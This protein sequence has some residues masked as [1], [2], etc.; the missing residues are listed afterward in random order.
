MINIAVLLT[1]HNRKDKT[2]SCLSSLFAATERYNL[3]KEEGKN[4]GLDIFITDDGCTDGTADAIRQHF[5][6]GQEITIIKGDGSLYWNR[7]MIAAWEEALK[8]HSKYDYYLLLND[9]TYLMDN[10]FEELF[11]T[12]EYTVAHYSRAGIYSGI[13]CSKDDDNVTTYGGDIFTNRFLSKLK[14]LNPNGTPQRCDMANANILLVARQVVDTIGIFWKGYHHGMSDS[15]YSL[16]AERNGIPIMLTP[17]Y[18]GRCD[19][20]HIDN[21]EE[22]RRLMAM[23]LKQ[24][25][26]YF[27]KPTRSNKDYL[28]FIARHQTIRLPMV[29]VGR[30]LCVYFPKIYYKIKKY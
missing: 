11:A 19:F 28:R 12:H 16:K 9:D 13:T 15:D 29:F 7:G 21:Y 4:V 30:M 17:C 2:L 5:S 8:S 27:S 25:R 10:L 1:C 20:D 18:V 6:S 22:G 3:S 24:R 14:R 23:S 26:A